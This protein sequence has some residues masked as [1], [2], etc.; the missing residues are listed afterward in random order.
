MRLPAREGKPMFQTHQP[1]RPDMPVRHVKYEHPSTIPV[2]ARL[3]FR[4]V[5]DDLAIEVAARCAGVG[6]VDV[7]EALNR[8]AFGQSGEKE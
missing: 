7:L 3:G 5:S 6:E 4:P 2:F 1:I 8:A